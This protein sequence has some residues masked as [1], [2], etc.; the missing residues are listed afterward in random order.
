MVSILV[1]Q[2]DWLGRQGLG[3]GQGTSS[4]FWQQV[5][6]SSCGQGTTCPSGQVVIQV[7]LISYLNGIVVSTR[8]S[9]NMVCGGK[10]DAVAIRIVKIDHILAAALEQGRS[11][12]IKNQVWVV[13]QNCRRRLCSMLRCSYT[14][15]GHDENEDVCDDKND[16]VVFYEI[17]ISMA[18]SLA[19]SLK[20]HALN[21]RIFQHWKIRNGMAKIRENQL[22]TLSHFVL[23]EK[24]GT[25]SNSQ[26]RI[27]FSQFFSKFNFSKQTRVK[28]LNFFVLNDTF[29]GYQTRSVWRKG[30]SKIKSIKK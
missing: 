5:S 24:T 20:S 26:F 11:R 16:V 6:C 3:I 27:A 9:I 2:Q 4:R 17:R 15:R 30:A 25:E 13:G 22:F 19:S 14:L 10:A 7:A 1:L 18:S 29:Y 8:S 28:S 23:T 12:T 21:C